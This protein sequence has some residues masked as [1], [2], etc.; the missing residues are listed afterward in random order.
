MKAIILHQPGGLDRL[1]LVEKEE[2]R[3][4]GPLEI[5]VRLRAS[6]VNYHDYLV[7]K[8]AAPAIEGLVPL[9][10]G[11]GEVVAVGSGVT[12]FAVGDSVISLF[13]P[14]WVDGA[15]LN[16]FGPEVFADVP[17][18]GVHGYAR[19]F[20][21]A[22]ASAFTRAPKGYSHAESATLVCAGLTAWR[23]LVVEGGVKAGDTVLVE[24]TGGVSIFAL[25]FAKASGA[26]V[27]ATSSSDEKLERL[28]A[29]GA[30]EVINYRSEPKWGSRA[31]QLTGGRGVDHV[32]DVGGPATLPQAFSACRVGASVAMVGL[33]TGHEGPLPT[34]V[35]MGRQLRVNCI[36]VGSRRAQIDMVR[37]VEVNGIKPVIDSHFP[38]SHLA[39]AFRYQEEGRHFGKIAIDI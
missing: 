10:D 30:D 31:R 19:E 14:N 21:T 33:L 39:D 18:D 34:T 27:I 17:G 23:A 24:G 20:A 8:G 25:Q 2:P 5:T 15:P 16:R 6:S 9:T 32:V 4:P 3:A 35:M 37:A 28:K 29:M 36:M 7:V 1:E 22:P 26:T 13:F 11:A 38:L 12:E